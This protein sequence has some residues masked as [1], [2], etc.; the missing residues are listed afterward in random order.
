MVRASFTDGGET[1]SKWLAVLAVAG[2]GASPAMAGEYGSWARKMEDRP[3]VYFEPGDYGRS[4]RFVSWDDGYFARGGGVGLEDGR[5][6]FDYDRSYP[7]EY[8]FYEGEPDWVEEEEEERVPYCETRTVRD[9]KRGS[10]PV[11]ICRN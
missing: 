6:R 8:A 2:F 11:R 10:G 5:V 7:Y 1:M 3:Y 9:G 4:G